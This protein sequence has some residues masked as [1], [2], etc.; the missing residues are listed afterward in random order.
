MGSK[1][2]QGA[3]L[4]GEAVSDMMKPQWVTTRVR[5]S[6]GGRPFRRGTK[7]L[8]FDLVHG[9]L[10]LGPPDFVDM[11]EVV[12]GEGA[13]QVGARAA[14]VAGEGVALADDGVDDDGDAEAAGHWGGGL[15]GAGVG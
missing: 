7:R 3:V 15:Q 9:L 4:H 14:D 13:D 1:R 2:S 11:G 12:V 8:G 6:P 10:D 5:S